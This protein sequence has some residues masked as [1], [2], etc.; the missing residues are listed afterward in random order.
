MKL[1][2]TRSLYIFWLTV[3]S[4]ISAHSGSQIQIDAD[5]YVGCHQSATV[6]DYIH[7]IYLTSENR[8][9]N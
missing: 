9:R 2:L 8:V 4:F 7:G 5:K 3:L 6:G 1:D